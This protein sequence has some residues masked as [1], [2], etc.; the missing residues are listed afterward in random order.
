MIGRAAVL[1]SLLVASP[2]AA[3]DFK[4]PST[5]RLTVE[6]NTAPD[7]YAAP[8]GVFEAGKV[9]E[10][11]IEGAIA[12]SV[13]RIEAPGLTPLQ[14]MRP[15]RDQIEQAGY[16]VVLDC[17]ADACGGYDFRFETETLPGPNM[18]VNIRAFHFLT[19][20]AGPKE[21]PSG[22]ITVLTSSS[23]SSAY[24]QIIQAGKL[25]GQPVPT[26]QAAQTVT[27]DFEQNFLAQGHVVLSGL[28]FDSGTSD[29][30]KGPF[31][32][33]EKLAAFLKDRSTIRIA[34]VGHT[35][36]VGGLDGNIALS[37][38]RAQSVRARLIEAYGI[39]SGRLEA[40]GMGYLAPVAS[41]LTAQGRDANR[42]VEAILLEE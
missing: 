13:W 36:S 42:R 35:D 1:L 30:G 22:A 33:L 14:V 20:I 27:G 19:A 8:I 4:M 38:R 10:L 17:A 32:S 9:P 21:A 39:A 18:Y 11:V 15:L 23:A 40:E 31:Q 3:L 2:V 28:D 12:R 24:A 29:L 6:R 41:N 34:L 5:A 16:Q 26:T 25:A 37:R 7:R